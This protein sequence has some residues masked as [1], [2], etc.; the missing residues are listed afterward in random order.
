MS[1]VPSDEVSVKSLPPAEPPAMGVMGGRESLS[2]HM[3][4]LLGS[5]RCLSL[6][7]PDCIAGRRILWKDGEDFVRVEDPALDEGRLGRAPAQLGHRAGQAH[8]VQHL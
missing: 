1:F 8:P 4:S 7:E 5:G 6:V 3:G 2:T